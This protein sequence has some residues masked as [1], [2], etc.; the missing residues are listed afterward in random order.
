MNRYVLKLNV[1]IDYLNVK[2]SLRQCLYSD[3]STIS[4]EKLYLGPLIKSNLVI[5]VEV[6][7]NKVLTDMR[8][9]MLQILRTWRNVKYR[10]Y[11]RSRRV[12]LQR[13][14]F[15]FF[16]FTILLRHRR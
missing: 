11:I 1:L 13:N 6:G 14:T 5:Y 7:G 12:R 9:P 15:V 10:M 4:V 16:N 2:Y 8:S 3:I